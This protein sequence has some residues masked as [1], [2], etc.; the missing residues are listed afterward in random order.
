MR[1]GALL[2]VVGLA[3]IAG[4]TALAFKALQESRVDACRDT[5]IGIRRALVPLAPPRDQRTAKTQ[6]SIDKFNRRID[7][8]IAGCPDQVGGAP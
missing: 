4:G 1:R 5:Y 7:A 6:A 8:L 3:I 2:I